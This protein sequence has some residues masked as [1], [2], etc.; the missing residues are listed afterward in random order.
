LIMVCGTVYI[1]HCATSLSAAQLL[2]LMGDG[3]K[4]ISV[5]IP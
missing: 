2:S 4:P 5:F 1:V 3:I